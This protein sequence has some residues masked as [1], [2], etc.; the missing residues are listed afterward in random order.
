MA[1]NDDLLRLFYTALSNDY[2]ALFRQD[3]E[4]IKSLKFVEFMRTF[5]NAIEP[6]FQIVR[7]EPGTFLI[8]VR[9]T[10]RPGPYQ[11]KSKIT[12]S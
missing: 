9:V 6:Q 8:P 2:G 7:R 11:E 5:E 3:G 1:V 10:S 12:F 4:E